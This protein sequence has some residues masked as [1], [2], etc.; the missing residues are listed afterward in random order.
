MPYKSLVER[1]GCV[2]F[3]GKSF[4][5]LCFDHV[6]TRGFVRIRLHLQACKKN[7]ANKHVC[8]LHVGSEHK[9]CSRR[10]AIRKRLTIVRIY[11]VEFFASVVHGRLG[12]CC[13]CTEYKVV[14]QKSSRVP[15]FAICAHVRVSGN[16]TACYP[17]GATGANL[18]KNET[19]N[20]ARDVCFRFISAHRF[21][22][23]TDRHQSGR[24]FS[25]RCGVWVW[26]CLR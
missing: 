18:K 22:G 2:A 11:I 12:V 8:L 1:T 6:A 5:T 20:C 3:L 19:L 14:E 21:E 25:L 10:D 13:H 4:D 26:C 23:E 16:L 7:S 15:G 17:C 24:L 9:R